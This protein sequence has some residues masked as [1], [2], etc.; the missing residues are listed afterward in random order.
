[1]R[2]GRLAQIGSRLCVDADD[3]ETA[4]SLAAVVALADE[5]VDVRE[6]AALGWIRKYYGVSQNRA[7][8]I[9]GEL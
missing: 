1:M 7:E 3:R 4:F 9:L 2:S 5:A 8:S 6:N